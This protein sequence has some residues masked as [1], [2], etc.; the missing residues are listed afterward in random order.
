MKPQL[1]YVL[2]GNDRFTRDEQVRGLKRRMLGEAFGEFN[3]SILSGD[4]VRV[5]DVRAVADAIPF[6]ADRRLIIVE[7]LLGRLA[8][9][10]KPA[11]RRGRSTASAAKASAAKAGTAKA[12]TAKAATARRGAT[13]A[14]QTVDPPNPLDE[15]EA[16]L[17][18][19]PA[20]TA[21]VFVED[22]IDPKAIEPRLPA[23]RAHVRG[24]ERPRPS[25]LGRW[26]E[27]RVKQHGGRMEAPAIRQLAQLAPD[28][29]GLLENE[30]LKLV[31]YADGRPVTLDD[32]LLLS[33]SPDVTIFNLLDAIGQN[34][35]G[36]ALG[37]LRLLF[38]RG[39]RS[40]TIVPQIAGSLR[41]LIQ[42]RELLDQ[43][44][45]GPALASRLGAHPFVAE[46]S[47][48][49]ARLYRVDQLEAML[50]RLL[51]TDRA[52]KTGEAEPE[53]ALELFICDLPRVS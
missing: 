33:A 31:T 9:Q 10:A 4:D 22:Q 36:K 32:V 29:L 14:A 19:L 5:R 16:F 40:E 50:R 27:R 25:D 26:I 18:D 44:L 49:Q 15:L 24:Y 17:A 39:E 48:R 34:E 28:D 51:A 23:G 20:T 35:R 13:S 11:A 7:G 45:H 47:E 41:R 21:L 2:W 3:L 8:G 12:G 37:Q 52:V 43:G 38:Q 53:L 30:V 6:L 46:K 1:I 42:A